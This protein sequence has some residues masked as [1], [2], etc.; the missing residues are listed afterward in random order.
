M[1]L[2]RSCPVAWLALA[3]CLV[4]CGDGQEAEEAD[5]VAAAAAPTEPDRP[6]PPAAPAAPPDDEGL[7]PEWRSIRGAA[8]QA[9]DP[10]MAEIEAGGPGPACVRYSELVVLF[11]QAEAFRLYECRDEEA[12]ASACREPPADPVR[13][14]EY[15]L[16]VNPT[17]ERGGLEPAESSADLEAD[18]DQNRQ[19]QH[20]DDR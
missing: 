17:A 13:Q 1:G 2:G 20:A 3:L 7:P 12:A 4:A 8:L 19:Q 10:C 9:F 15:D 16:A 18:S 6:L 5:S 14:S 11:H